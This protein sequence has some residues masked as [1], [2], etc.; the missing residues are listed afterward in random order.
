MR[1]YKSGKIALRFKNKATAFIN[2][3]T[4]NT[5]KE[6]KNAFVDL[7]GKI[8][9]VVDQKFVSEDEILVILEAKFREKL[10]SHLD[11]YLQLSDTVVEEDPSIIYFDLDAPAPYLLLSPKEQPATVSEKEFEAFK[12]QHQILIQGAD[13]NDDMLLNIFP[14]GYVS[15]TKGCFL[16]QEILAR[17][18]Y[19]KGRTSE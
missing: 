5:P 12:K 11:K 17:V 13:Y 6:S 1:L 18:H 2:A 3:Y 15:Y 14:E 10:R 19:R 4:T 8:I 9:A 7:R 16:G